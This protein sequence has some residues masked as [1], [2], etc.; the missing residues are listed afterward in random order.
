MQ[1]SL[2]KMPY[3]TSPADGTKGKS[4][5]DAKV[6]GAAAKHGGGESMNNE[7]ATVRYGLNNKK[8]KKCIRLLL[9]GVL[10]LRI[11]PITLV[12]SFLFY[13]FGSLL[14]LLLRAVSVS[15]CIYLSLVL[16]IADSVD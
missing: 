6:A 15:L 2:M 16:G 9:A 11:P 3:D 1:I 13:S 12:I 5:R 14:A 4:S 10:I 7:L 8:K